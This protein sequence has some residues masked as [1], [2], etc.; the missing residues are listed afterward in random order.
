MRV[1]KRDGTLQELQMAKIQRAILMAFQGMR[2]QPDVAPLVHRVMDR[3]VGLEEPYSVEVVSDAVEEVLAAGGW[4]DVARSFMRY[5]LRRAELRARRLR[6][7]DGAVSGY[8]HVGKYARYEEEM[9]RRELFPETV[10]RDEEM[11]IRRWPELEAEIRRAFGFVYR[12]EGMPSMRSMQFGGAAIEKNNERI[13]NCSFMHISRWRS[14]QEAF[15]LLL[16]GC[17]VGYS[18]QW[19]HVDCLTELKEI[20][21][22]DVCHHTIDDSIEGWADALGRLLESYWGERNCYV[23]FNYSEIRPEGAPLKT[24]GGRAP[25]HL[26]LKRCLEAVRGILERAAGRK[27]RPVECHDIL[28]LAAEAVLAGG[29]RRSSLISIFSADDTEMIYCK[30]KGNFRPASGGDP[31]LNSHR[32]MAN[33]SAALLRGNVG[34]EVFER[35]IRV[36][37][38]NYGCPGFYFTNDL[39]YGCNP[40]GEIGM[41]PMI[42][43]C[44]ACQIWLSPVHDFCDCGG[45]AVVRSG[46]SFCNLTEVNIAA[47]RDADHLFSCVKAM[48]LIGTLQAAY[49]D[50]PYLGQVTEEIVRREALLGVGMTG[51]MD[52]RELI[53]DP[54]V[55]DLAALVAVNENK[56]VAKLIGTRPAARVTTV[57]PSGTSSLELGGVG[58]GIHPRWARRY[59]HRITANPMEAPAQ[60]FRSVNPHMVEVK[61]NGDWSIMFPVQ[62]PDGAVTVKEMAASEFL[63]AV[64]LVYKHWICGGTAREDSA[65]RLTHN[66]SCTV[67][68]R[69]GELEE[70]IDRVWAARKDV[71]AMTFVP[72][73]IDQKFRYAPRQAIVSEQDEALWNHLIGL[74]KP[75]DWA[76]FEES[77]DQTTLVGEGA[78]VSGVCEVNL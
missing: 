2:E 25:G 7:D 3:L 13:Y 48:A 35:L 14:F 1:L 72:Y 43:W 67:T 52:N 4:L 36:A 61:P 68:V 50:F 26:P 57:K 63:D 41:W 73:L 9:G 22:R 37:Q 21:Q 75:V 28:C 6:P 65:P 16:C 56:R 20:D 18:V 55:L 44:E 42:G 60:Y 54:V 40:C 12:R 10:S 58:S 27:L 30:A 76:L 17:G 33:N 8:I 59:I 74:Y 24:S 47:M 51:I 45:Y 11:H 15:Y 19:R 29:I 71:C 5:R 62:A 66:V 78:C 31:G 70:V 46:V 69:D 23:E 49:T 32:E 64:E 34:R 39:D 53:L 38:A 77:S